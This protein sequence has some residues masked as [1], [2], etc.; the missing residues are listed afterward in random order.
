VASATI[1]K[2]KRRLRRVQRSRLIGALTATKKT[3]SSPVFSW[4]IK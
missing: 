2:E 1:R 3:P 4:T